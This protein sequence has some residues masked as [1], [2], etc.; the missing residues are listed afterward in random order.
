MDA[1]FASA[2]RKVHDILRQE[3][4]DAQFGSNINWTSEP[5]DGISE[6]SWG[7]PEHAG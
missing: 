4:R 3:G 2:R 6:E 5:L 1:E 7:R